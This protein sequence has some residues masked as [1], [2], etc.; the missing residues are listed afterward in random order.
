MADSKPSSPMS[1]IIMPDEP[2]TDEELAAALAF[3]GPDPAIPVEE[4]DD[5]TRAQVEATARTVGWKPTSDRGADWCMCKYIEKGERVARYDAEAD[6]MLAALDEQRRR[7]EAW[8]EAVKRPVLS[9][10]EHMYRLLSEWALAQRTDRQATFKLPSGRVETRA[11]PEAVTKVA[12]KD[13]AAA[14]VEWARGR[15]LEVNVKT[16]E[17][18]DLK[19]ATTAVRVVDHLVFVLNPDKPF[20]DTGEASSV[21]SPWDQRVGLVVEWEPYPDDAE[22]QPWEPDGEWRVTDPE[23]GEILP[24]DSVMVRVG[25][26]VVDD[27]T[28]M[29]LDFLDVR[30]AET[31]VNVVP[32]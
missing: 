21:W 32:A 1:A 28:G 9:E 24:A 13:S 30:E 8:R 4:L 15:G 3:E 25:R 11:K 14:A 29:H 31:T 23:N 17:S 16:E 18:V 19:V 20:D 7:I 26:F 12:G 22:R 5:D 10:Q 6:E 2:F 27:R